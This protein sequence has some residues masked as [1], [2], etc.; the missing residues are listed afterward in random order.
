MLVWDVFA[1][2]ILLL[3]K[4]PMNKTIVLCASMLA[5]FGMTSGFAMDGGAAGAEAAEALALLNLV[6]RGAAQG[7][8]RSVHTSLREEA[9]VHK[10]AEL[11]LAIAEIEKTDFWTVPLTFFTW[12]TNEIFGQI[13]ASRTQVDLCNIAI[14]TFD[15]RAKEIFQSYQDLFAQWNFI[16]EQDPEKLTK[17]LIH[18]LVGA[19]CKSKKISRTAIAESIMNL[20]REVI[21]AFIATDLQSLGCVTPEKEMLIK[22][23]NT[24]FCVWHLLTNT[25]IS[26]EGAARVARFISTFCGLF[27]SSA[28]P[29]LWTVVDQDTLINITKLY[30][31]LPEL[32]DTKYR[33]AVI[34]QYACVH[35]SQVSVSRTSEA[36]K[37]PVTT[38]SPTSV[39]EFASERICPAG[40]V[41]DHRVF[42]EYAGTGDDVSRYCQKRDLGYNR[43]SFLAGKHEREVRAHEN[44]GITYLCEENVA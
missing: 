29:L 13:A 1:R 44:A 33:Q 5:L 26:Y 4:G 34:D 36:R 21:P 19:E 6:R 42:E 23:G 15:T 37:S 20:Q 25:G 43:I 22:C 2:D 16:E 9:R 3:L 30:A 32:R 11:D 24:F 28:K 14:S 31:N 40:P 18:T 7:A 12:P 38:L 27:H 35:N 8:A 41:L 39:T 17:L 10:R